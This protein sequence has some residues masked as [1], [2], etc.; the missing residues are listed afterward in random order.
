MT[1]Y[2]PTDEMSS[3][4]DLLASSLYRQ[5]AV[6]ICSNKPNDRTILSPNGTL[7][8]RRSPLKH[9]QTMSMNSPAPL[10]STPTATPTLSQRIRMGLSLRASRGEDNNAVGTDDVVADDYDDTDDRVDAALILSER[11]RRHYFIGTDYAVALPAVQDLTRNDAALKSFLQSYVRITDDAFIVPENDITSAELTLMAYMNQ[12]AEDKRRIIRAQAEAEWDQQADDDV[13]DGTAH[14]QHQQHDANKTAAKPTSHIATISVGN[15][16][17]VEFL[18]LTPPPPPLETM[19]SAV[20]PIRYPSVEIDSLHPLIADDIYTSLFPAASPHAQPF[21]YYHEYSFVS[22]Q[23]ETLLKSAFETVTSD[24][25]NTDVTAS[26]YMQ[27][28]SNQTDLAEINRD[29]EQIYR[30]YVGLQAS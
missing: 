10:T 27:S 5:R 23:C 11:L 13:D 8:Q 6:V 24:E 1:L 3:F 28:Q 15:V 9:R 21:R 26:E 14:A 12:E 20:N 16:P 17:G 19:I 7:N 22:G 29:N 4:D 18:D 25:R 2:G 30:Q